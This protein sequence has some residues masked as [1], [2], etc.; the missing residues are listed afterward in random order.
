MNTRQ[1]VSAFFVVGLAS[2]S[3]F[4]YAD[5]AVAADDQYTKA[6]RNYDTYCIQCH[7]ID[8]NGQGLNTKDLST[9]PRDHTDPKG[10]GDISDDELHKAIKEGGLA[11]NKS[12]LMPT[13]GGVLTDEEIT[14]MVA[15]LRH[16]CQCGTS[17]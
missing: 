13:W 4:L 2:T 17:K 15:Y 14:E 11:V 3:S 7:G 6:A 8:R 9:Q 5:T 16:V 12:I 10:M 1:L